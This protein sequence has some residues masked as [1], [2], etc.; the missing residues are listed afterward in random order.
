MPTAG[1][2]VIILL[3][4]GAAAHIFLGGGLSFISDYQVWRPVVERR[5]QEAIMVHPIGN[6]SYL[7]SGEIS[8]NYGKKFNVT[9]IALSDD[10]TNIPSNFYNLFTTKV[11][12]VYSTINESIFT[13]STNEVRGETYKKSM[14]VSKING[15]V[16]INITPE[17]IAG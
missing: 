16:H 17:I 10:T 14:Y 7:Y 9:S 3:L 8:L 5:G 2:F 15:G 12:T 6:N 13:D 11:T 4:I 1:R